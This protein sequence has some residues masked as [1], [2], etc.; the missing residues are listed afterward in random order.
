MRSGTVMAV[1]N[2]LGT[3]A[4]YTDYSTTDILGSTLGIS[5]DVTATAPSVSLIASVTSGTWTVKVGTR[6]IF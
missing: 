2:A 5:F 1:W 3:A 6:V 4:G